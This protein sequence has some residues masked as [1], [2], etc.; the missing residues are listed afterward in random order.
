M[1]SNKRH[2]RPRPSPQHGSSW[3]VP[4][5]TPPVT[6]KLKA[7]KAG[8]VIP[9]GATYLTFAFKNNVPHFFFLLPHGFKKPSERKIGFR[10]N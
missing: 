6:K 3:T 9:E 5:L 10:V 8:Q 4:S 7:F 2:R 1:T